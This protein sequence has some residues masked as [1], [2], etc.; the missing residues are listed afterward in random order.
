MKLVLHEFD[1]E[2][3]MNK[4]FMKNKF[5]SLKAECS[6]HRFCD[7]CRLFTDNRFCMVD[8][9][10]GSAPIDWGVKEE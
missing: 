6:S 5:V 10:L 1:S 9:V 4:S 2:V 3:P 8:V 7:T